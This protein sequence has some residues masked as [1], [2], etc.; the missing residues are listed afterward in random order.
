MLAARND[1]GAVSL[2]RYRASGFGLDGRAGVLID[3]GAVGLC[4]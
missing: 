1:L 2:E 3:V 4:F